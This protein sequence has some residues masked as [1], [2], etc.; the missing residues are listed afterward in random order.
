[1]LTHNILLKNNNIPPLYS[2][3]GCCKHL[4]SKQCC[5]CK[6][7]SMY[8]LAEEYPIQYKVFWNKERGLR[9]YS[10]DESE[11]EIGKYFISIS[12]GTTMFQICKVAKCDCFVSGKALVSIFDHSL[13]KPCLEYNVAKIKTCYVSF[14]D[15]K[16]HCV[17]CFE[18]DIEQAIHFAKL[19]NGLLQIC[20]GT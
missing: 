5:N 13:F 8:C 4:G 10:P 14:T 15:G 1:M 9:Y 19:T 12:K 20:L 11:L 7:A 3:C 2:E 18:D 17:H 6:D 16:V